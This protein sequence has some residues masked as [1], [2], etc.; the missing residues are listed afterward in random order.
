MK[1]I[2]PKSVSLENRWYNEHLVYTH[3]PNGFLTLEVT[4]GQIVDSGEFFQQREIYYGEGGLFEETWS[5]Y[6]NSRGSSRAE[7]GGVSYAGEGGLDVSPPLSW[8]FEPNF[9]LSFPTESVHVMRYKDVN[10]RMEI[11]YPYFLYDLFSVLS[12]ES[13]GGTNNTFKKNKKI[14]K[15]QKQRRR[16]SKESNFF[17]FQKRNTIPVC[18]PCGQNKNKYRIKNAI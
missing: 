13:F 3:V 9:L 17:F 4:D 2:L 12:S 15:K 14:K 16:T 5:A 1:P 6:L 18:Y 8:I 10:D 11:L 7:L